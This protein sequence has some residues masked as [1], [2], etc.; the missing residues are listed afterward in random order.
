VVT[1]GRSPLQSEAP[2]LFKVNEQHPHVWVLEEVPHG[3]VFAIAVIIWKGKPVVVEHPDKTGITA[4]I[5]TRRESPMV[6]GGKEEHIGMGDKGS[7][8]LVKVITSARGNTVGNT[9]GV[10]ALLQGAI[11]VM[12]IIDTFHH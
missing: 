11:A 2:L 4:F 8:K 12:I 1:N 6:T 5:R 9:S 7:G 3:L 10:K